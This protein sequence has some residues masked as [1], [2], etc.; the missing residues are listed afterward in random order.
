MVKTQQDSFSII[1]IN[2]S[3]ISLTIMLYFKSGHNLGI[4]AVYT[5]FP[6]RNFFCLNKCYKFKKK[7]AHKEESGFVWKSIYR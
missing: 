3:R 6:L 4:N 2:E 5:D 1:H 7:L